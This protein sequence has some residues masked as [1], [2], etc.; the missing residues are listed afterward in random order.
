M[1]ALKIAFLRRG[2]SRSG[3]AEAYLKR[4]GAGLVARGHEAVLVTGAEWP[5]NEWS[6]GP[7]E[8]LRGRSPVEFAD[9]AT[10]L[11]MRLECDVVMSLERVWKC[12]V[13]R[14][15][16]GL[17]RSWLERRARAG[18]WLTRASMALNRGKHGD[19][20]R[21]EESLFARGGAGRVIANSAMVREEIVEASGYPAERI[22]VVY[23]GVPLERFR[24]TSESRAATRRR[25]NLGEE[26]V[27]LLFVGSGWERKGLRQA[28]EALGKLADKTLRLLVA[29][30]GDAAKYAG[31]GVQF[32][33][34]VDDVPAL[35]AAADLFVLP[36]LYDPFS[37][38]CLEALASG[39]PVI[40]TTANGFAEVIED[41][42]H[43]SVLPEN[44]SEAV[45]AAIE[46]WREPARRAAAR[47]KILERAAQFPI[48]RNV[49]ETLAI[50]LQAAASAEST[51]G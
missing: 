12:D 36:T 40:T 26:E 48:E 3:G 39:L 49:E 14:A 6:C 13:F 7:I 8:R 20:L 46:H 2:Y 50:L 30:R 25:L 51:S 18:G 45:A 32:L 33:D 31:P 21:L 42:V 15:G 9:Q 1:D 19:V 11:R 24:L 35:Y 37:N 16:D 23:N 38:A 22:E 4:L 5:A 10:L 27:A 47:P 43:G 29:G 17:H 41:G 34:E 28:V 44:D